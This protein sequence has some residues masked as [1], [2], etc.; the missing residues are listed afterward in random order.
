MVGIGYWVLGVWVLGIGYLGVWW[1]VLGDG[2]SGAGYWVFSAEC[3]LL[4]IGCWV[5]GIAY[6]S[7]IA[8]VLVMGR[9]SAVSAECGETEIP[10]KLPSAFSCGV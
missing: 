8:Y 3:W 10:G 5:L 9:A 4:G 7:G 1:W 2:C 6:Y